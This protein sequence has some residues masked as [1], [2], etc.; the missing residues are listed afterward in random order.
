M[1]VHL[2]RILSLMLYKLRTSD[3][4]RLSVAASRGTYFL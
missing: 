3:V 2:S 4:V 1:I